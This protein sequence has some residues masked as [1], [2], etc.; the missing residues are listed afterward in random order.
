M[1]TSLQFL[2]L[3]RFSTESGYFYPDFE[4]SY[5]VFGCAL[6]QSPVVLINHALTGNSNVSGPDGWWREIVGPGCVIDTNR[7]CVVVF[8]VPGNG[9]DGKPENL[10]RNYRDF[11]AR[12]IARLFILGL[13]ALG[14]EQ[15]YAVVGASLGGGIAWEMAF[16]RPDFMR[17]LVPV[18]SDWKAS[19]W[20]IAHNKTQQHILANSSQPVHDARMMAML[21][22]RTAES[23]KRKFNRERVRDSGEFKTESWLLHHGRA[24]QERFRLESYQ[25]MNHLLSSVDVTRGRGVFSELAAQLKMHV[26]QVA[27]DSD[28]F[29]VPQEIKE[30]QGLLGKAGV[31]NDYAEMQSV[32]GHDAFLIEHDQLQAILEPVFSP[33]APSLSMPGLRKELA[34]VK[35]GGRSLANGKGFLQVLDII[36]DKYRRKERFVVV[37]SARGNTTKW[38]E[39]LLDS[40]AQ[41]TV[42]LDGVRSL[43]AYQQQVAPGCDLSQEMKLLSRLLDGVSL[44]REVSPRVKDQVLSL[45]EVMAVKTIA[46]ALNSQGVPAELV[47]ARDWLRSDDCFGHAQPLLDESRKNAREYFACWTEPET[48]PYKVPVVTGFIAATRDG[49]TTTLGR[50]GSNYSAALLANFLDAAEMQNYTHVDG[51]YTA[52]PDLVPGAKRIEELTY[53]EASELAHHG[54]HILHAKTVGPLMEKNIPLRILNT[55]RPGQAGTLVTNQVEQAGVRSVTA[56]ENMALVTLRG[57]GL[58]GKAGVDARIFTALGNAGIS[59]GVISQGSSERGIGLVVDNQDARRAK[60]ALELAFSED[61][62]RGDVDSVDVQTDLAVVSIIGQQLDNFHRS[63]HSLISNGIV[64]VLINSTVTGNNIF[65]VLKKE[66]LAKAV[67]VIH[68]RVLDMP[69][70]IN[71]FLFGVGQVGSALIEQI[72]ASR[73]TILE[74]RGVRLNIVAVANSRRLLLSVTGIGSD[75]RE[76]L[77][78]EGVSG[79]RLNDVIRFARQ[80]H[81]ENLIAVDNTD[82]ASFVENYQPLVENGFDLVS[83]NKHANTRHF[84]FY[85]RLRCSLKKRHKK[86]LYETNVGAGLPLIDTIRLL[87][88][89]GENI[90]AITGVFSGSLSYLF[91]TFSTQDRSFSDILREAINKGLTEPDPREDLCGNDVARK[92]LILARELDLHNELEDVQVQNLIPKPLRQGSLSHFMSRLDVLDE[93]FSTLKAQQKP[94]HVL[95]Y[96]GKLDGDLQQDKGCLRVRLES[97]PVDSA[98][99]QVQGADSVFEIYTES[100]GE[101][102]IVIQGAGAGAR[103]TARGVLGDILRLSEKAV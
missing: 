99:G 64:P 3:S 14:V 97:V 91:N 1:N 96:V 35:F 4:L 89:S 69:T 15:L 95:R 59:I 83:S 16:L 46:F 41:G 60:Y 34:I 58:L 78:K 73:Q 48:G 72:L 74:R 65:L 47:D 42:D 23:F 18:A 90:T 87:H 11:T 81:L 45:G 29:F 85:R 103:V 52:N 70:T 43:V 66:Q 51:I 102:P 26:L 9:Y 98:L 13:R 86:Y 57:Q 32:H 80:C 75:W 21:F 31:S 28:V 12:D 92:L 88:H 71:L 61:M 38:L 76:R 82:S 36:K 94:G 55:F 33:A 6:G 63:Y 44:L 40:A 24:L 84:S 56:Q 93:H 67:R 2:K 54:A 62:R 19:D 25:M 68:G 17:Y 77:D 53:Q 39:S 49:D 7:Y 30:T 27:I 8:N 20:I 79:Y 10:I 37:A 50:N 100:Y 101:R 5:Q 22:Y